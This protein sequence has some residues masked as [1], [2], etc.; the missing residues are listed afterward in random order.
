[1][2]RLEVRPR[3]LT[4]VCRVV[5]LVV[6][7]SFAAVSV[8]LRGGSGADQFQPADQV[9]MFLLGLLLAGLVLLL[10]R[11][12]LVADEEGLWVR[13]LLSQK[14]VPWQVVVAVRLDDGS[15]WASLDLQDDDQLG[16]FAI[17][18]NDGEQAV[19]AVLT[20][21]ALLRASREPRPGT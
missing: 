3:R 14:W 13:N 1:M 15:P 2:S 4:R 21:R 17:Q 20:L 6:A 18:A 7:G 9:A 12:R 8:A 11:S 16:L 10:T 19:Q 5:A